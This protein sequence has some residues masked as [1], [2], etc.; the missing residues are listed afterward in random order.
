MD[1]GTIAEASHASPSTDL[2][3]MHAGK[4]EFLALKWAVTENFRNCLNYSTSFTVYTDN[5]PLTYVLSSAKLSAIGHRRVAE[6]AN[7]NFDIKHRPGKSN[8]DRD[9]LSRL[10]LD[11]SEYMGACARKMEKNAICAT[12]QAVIHQKDEAAPWVTVSVSASVGIV[13]AEPVVTDLVSRQLTSE[14]IQ[15]AQREDP[16]PSLILV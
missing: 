7:F 8:I 10:P 1:I 9:I 4:L 15:K 11:P 12:K 2:S 5:N 3:Y 16:D 14:E 13:P 6:Q